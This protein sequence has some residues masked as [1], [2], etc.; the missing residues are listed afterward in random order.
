M[1]RTLMRPG[2]RSERIQLAV[3]AAVREL[4][5]VTSQQKLTISQIAQRADVPPSTIYRRWKT[6][7]QLLADVAGDRFLAD[8]EPAD[9]G[10]FRSD[11]AVWLEQFIDDIS[12][13]PGRSLL[14]ERLANV[15]V[16]Q[17]AAGYAFMN[18]E[19]ICDRSRGRDE[20]VPLPDRLI[21]LIVAPVIYRIVFCGQ[22]ISKSYQMELVEIAIGSG[23]IA[24][25]FARQPSIG[26][27]VTAFE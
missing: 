20:I 27:Y 10:S 15:A 7:D 1:A 11:M 2:G 26:S 18:I 3:H 6:L 19:T 22:A 12:S 8:A 21:D 4:A 17:R 14:N 13:G 24:T 9:T 16:A 5:T 23:A 25:D